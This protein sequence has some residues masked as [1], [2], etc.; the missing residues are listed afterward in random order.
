[1]KNI[2]LS[3]SKKMKRIFQAGKQRYDNFVGSSETAKVE[4]TDDASVELKVEKK[5]TNLFAQ[6]APKTT[7]DLVFSKLFNQ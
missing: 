1:M 5:P 4:E 2:I 7:R 6:N 3:A